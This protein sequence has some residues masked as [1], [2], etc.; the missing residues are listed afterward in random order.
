M[1]C[2]RSAGGPP[3]G[4]G[5][6]NADAHFVRQ[7]EKFFGFEKVYLLQN[8]FEWK[9]RLCR[10]IVASGRPPGW[11]Q[12]GC[13]FCVAN[14]QSCTVPVGVIFCHHFGQSD[15]TPAKLDYVTHSLEGNKPGARGP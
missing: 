6:A 9:P 4:V 2:S 1:L 5:V 14:R 7:T 8:S 11:R 10:P 15:D 13:E 3:P 12:R